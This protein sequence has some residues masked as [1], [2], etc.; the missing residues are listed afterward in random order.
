MALN[1][2][3]KYGEK[4]KTTILTKVKFIVLSGKPLKSCD[5]PL[6]LHC[7][8]DSGAVFFPLK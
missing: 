3:I 2:Y 5:L 7:V 6:N 1:E 4:S 8:V